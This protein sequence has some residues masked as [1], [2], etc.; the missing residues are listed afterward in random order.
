MKRRSALQ[1]LAATIAPNVIAQENYP[2]RPIKLV[3]PFAP[4]EST[5]AIAR[6][7]AVQLE[8]R[9]VSQS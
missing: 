1:S 9:L 7:L 3:V 8:L 6:K 5:D 2:S 4:A